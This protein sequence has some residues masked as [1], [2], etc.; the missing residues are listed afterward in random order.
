MATATKQKNFYSS[1]DKEAARNVNILAYLQ[2][3]G[4]PFTEISNGTFQH[5]DHD[6]LVYTANKN[7]LNWFSKQEEKACFNCVDAAIMMYD[8]TFMQAMKDIQQKTGFS[9]DMAVQTSIYDQKPKNFEYARDVKEVDNPKRATNYL[10]EQ[11]GLDPDIVAYAM[12]EGIVAGDNKGNVVFK[13]MNPRVF[14]HQ[15]VVGAS[16]RGTRVIPEERRLHPDMKYFR[17]IL[18]GSERDT[19]FFIDVGKPERIVL[20]ESAIDV[21]SYMSRLK[22]EGRKSELRNTRFASMEGLKPKVYRKHM[23]ALHVLHHE[24]GR[25]LIPKV[26]FIVDEDVPAQDFLR[27]IQMDKTKITYT[28]EPIQNYI[29]TEKIPPIKGQENIK[30]QND[31]LLY[32]RGQA[33]KKQQ[34]TKPVWFDEAALEKYVEDT[35]QHFTTDPAEGMHLWP[36]GA[37]TSSTVDGIRGDEHYVIASYFEHTPVPEFV[38]LNKKNSAEVAAA[39]L[40]VVMLVPETQMALKAENQTLTEAQQQVLNN[41]SYELS[42]FCEGIELTNEKLRELGIQNPE[43]KALLPT[44]KPEIS[45]NQVSEQPVQH[46]NRFVQKQGR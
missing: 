17:K 1:E 36:N 5:M 7:V 21:M 39:G 16:M 3:C 9:P 29:E 24:E 42:D 8:Y 15:E 2:A 13:W 4:E 43:S 25:M 22:M 20:A 41:S 34:V 12:K 30:D 14:G 46:E 19:G 38:F 28:N 23:M 35:A 44:E 45:T 37:V 6:S 26:T 32:L 18:S 33:E 40:G 31:Y 10:V 11:R 27:N